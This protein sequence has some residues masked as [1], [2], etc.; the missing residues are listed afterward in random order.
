MSVVINTFHLQGQIKGDQNFSGTVQMGRGGAG[1][2]KTCMFAS[3]QLLM[4]ISH[5]IVGSKGTYLPHMHPMCYVLV[6][7]IL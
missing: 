2:S 7:A 5:T 3:I 6:C 1:G 4:Y